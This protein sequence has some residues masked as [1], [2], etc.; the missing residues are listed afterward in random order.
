MSK[1]VLLLIIFAVLAYSTLY[2]SGRSEKRKNTLTDK[3]SELKMLEKSEKKW[4]RHKITS[5]KADII[6]IRGT[7][8]PEEINITVADD[9]VTDWK[10]G[11]T[12]RASL[13]ESFIQSLT[14]KSMFEKMK[15]SLES[16]KPSPMVLKAV[17][18]EKLG[19]IK[20]LSRVPSGETAAKGRAPFD[21]GYRIEVASLDIVF[22]P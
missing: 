12:D 20:S 13:S 9:I 14:V 19:Y 22:L 21:A 17:Y 2:A 6:Y 16:D 8:V 5:Y 7:F 3:K 15:G 11:N 4:D 1:K 18:D 10:T